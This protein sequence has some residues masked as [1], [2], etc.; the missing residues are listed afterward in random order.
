MRNLVLVSLLLSGLAGC[1]GGGGSNDAD[2]MGDAAALGCVN[3]SD[4]IDDAGASLGRIC[5]ESGVVM[6]GRANTVVD[7]A[8]SPNEYDRNG[9]I[10]RAGNDAMIAMA[11]A[12]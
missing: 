10:Y 1:V 3:R 6:S 12:H 8:V 2:A 9:D 11:L 4:I 7:P 5:G